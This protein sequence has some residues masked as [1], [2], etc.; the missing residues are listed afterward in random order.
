MKVFLKVTH[1]G[2]SLLCTD[3]DFGHLGR[4]IYLRLDLVNL[5]LVNLDLVK[6]LI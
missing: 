1:M 2:H 4:Y 3:L 6:Y 5:D